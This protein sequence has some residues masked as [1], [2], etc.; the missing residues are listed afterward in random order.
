MNHEWRRRR[1][2]WIK[3]MVSKL[4]VEKSNPQESVEVELGAGAGA[5]SSWVRPEPVGCVLFFCCSFIPYR[6]GK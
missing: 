1:R 6:Q 2:C 4:C 3:M 5:G